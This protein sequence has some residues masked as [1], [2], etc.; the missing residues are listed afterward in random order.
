MSTDVR[1][2]SRAIMADIPDAVQQHAEQAAKHVAD[3]SRSL[4]HTASAHPF[5]F[6]IAVATAGIFI[7]AWVVARSTRR[8]WLATREASAIQSRDIQASIA[9]AQ[10]AANAAAK[11]AAASARAVVDM[12][13]ALIVPTQFQSTAIVRNDRVI[14]YRI[15]AVFENTGTTVA[16]RFTGTANIVMWKGPLPEDFKYP[17][18][19]EAIA[20]NAFVAPRLKIPFPVDIA[21]QDLLDI[22][23]KKMRGFIYGWVEYDDVFTSSARRRT[24]FCVEIE[25]IGNPLVMPSKGAPAALG[26]AGYGKYNGIDE[27]CFYRPGEKPPVGGLP[28]PTQ[29]PLENRTAERQLP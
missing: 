11:S 15:T 24:E 6:V 12:Q 26:F 14:A 22:M 21:I 7:F 25:I 19:M 18:R 23:N 1:S 29:P 17:D 8:L 28:E 27:D 10:E 16:R 5:E 4:W 9:V 2:L 13:R 20:P 3:A